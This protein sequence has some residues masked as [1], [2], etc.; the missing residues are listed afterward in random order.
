M[1]LLEGF[2][3]MKFRLKILKGSVLVLPRPDS[4]QARNGFSTKLGEY[5]QQEFLLW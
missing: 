5:L 2:P 3:M 4:I 1:Y